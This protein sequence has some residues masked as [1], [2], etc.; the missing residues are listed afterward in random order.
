MSA[1]LLQWCRTVS[2]LSG[3]VFFLWL[4]GRVQKHLVTV[5]VGMGILLFGLGVWLVLSVI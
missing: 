5:K 3:T 1:T 4:G 2:Y